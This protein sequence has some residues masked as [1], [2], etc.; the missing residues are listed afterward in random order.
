M[1]LDPVNIY[2]LKSATN[3]RGPHSEGKSLQF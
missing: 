3:L 1:V 2:C